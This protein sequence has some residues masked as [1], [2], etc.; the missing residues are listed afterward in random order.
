M[1]GSAE[2]L[3]YLSLRLWNQTNPGFQL[4][5]KAT[6]HRGT[7]PGL[8]VPRPECEFWVLALVSHLGGPKQ[9]RYFLFFTNED[10]DAKEMYSRPPKW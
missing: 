9:G 10:S 7:S 6:G 3:Y 2:L 5:Q 1:E 4:L 8:R